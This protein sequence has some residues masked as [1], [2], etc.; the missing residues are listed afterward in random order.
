MHILLQSTGLQVPPF[1]FHI[2]FISSH[3]SI[4]FGGFMIVIHRIHANF[5]F[6]ACALS[7]AFAGFSLSAN[8]GAPNTTA[9]NSVAYEVGQGWVTHYFDE[10]TQTRWFKYGEVGGHSYCIEAV[11][12]SVSPIQLDPNLAV[13][14]D[15]TGATALSVSG[16]PL[17]NND[18]GGNPNFIKGSRICYI[19]PTTFGTLTVRSAKVN[20]PIVASSGDAGNIRVR[21]VDTT[22]V[23]TEASSGIQLSSGY[24]QNP[25]GSVVLSNSSPLAVNIV[26]SF[27][28]TVVNFYPLP[29]TVASYTMSTQPLPQAGPPDGD[30]S[31]YARVGPVFVAHNAPPGVLKGVARTS[32]PIAGST[33]S[34]PITT[35]SPLTAK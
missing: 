25:S 21:I 10:A 2:R 14:T 34:P 24:G 6:L 23:A 18:G 8:A 28:P 12:G 33:T 26:I 35:D 30:G 22:L 16:T 15:A 5:L 31:F 1:L 7:T 4:I 3:L 20:V 9:A 19:A 32:Q 13:F 27:A 29:V 17:T 11:Q